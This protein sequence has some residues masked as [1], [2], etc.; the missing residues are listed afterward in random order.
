MVCTAHV[1]E[2]ESTPARRRGLLRIVDPAGH[3]Q[4]AH[5][6]SCDFRFWRRDIRNELWFWT[7]SLVLFACNF[8]CTAD[9]ILIAELLALVEN[10]LSLFFGFLLQLDRFRRMMVV[11]QVVVGQSFTAAPLQLDPCR[12]TPV[13]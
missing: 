10:S 6:S 4:F 8:E 12:I 2:T 13:G 11:I 1:D 7:L 3:V 9:F 5:V